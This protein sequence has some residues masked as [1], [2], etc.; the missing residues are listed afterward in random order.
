MEIQQ[1]KEAI[2][3]AELEVRQIIEKLEQMTGLTVTRLEL[4]HVNFDGRDITPV[5]IHAE[6]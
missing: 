1:A 3:T 5:K 4:G 6:I 2:N